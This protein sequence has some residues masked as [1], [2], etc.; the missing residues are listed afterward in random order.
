MSSKNERGIAR[1]GFREG[2]L[3]FAGEKN[4]L[5]S[6]EPFLLVGDV[7]RRET[8]TYEAILKAIAAGSRTPQEIGA[9][10]GLAS[11]YLSDQRRRKVV[12]KITLRQ[13]PGIGTT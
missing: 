13:P 8:Q 9:A 5:V 4:V 7:V 1:A 11:S 12:W 6:S 10:L 3:R 2:A